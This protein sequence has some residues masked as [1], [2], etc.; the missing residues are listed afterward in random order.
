[1]SSFDRWYALEFYYC[2]RSLLFENELEVLT[3]AYEDAA[4]MAD[5][6]LT[7]LRHHGKGVVRVIALD[8][9]PSDMRHFADS[10]IR[11]TGR[12]LKNWEVFGLNQ[13]GKR[14]RY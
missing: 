6:Q 5:L 2:G 11:L 3:E 7:G 1:M 12:H 8:A 13:S 4:D 10:L 14:W 9:T